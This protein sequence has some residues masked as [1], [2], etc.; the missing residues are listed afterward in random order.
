MFSETINHEFT[1]TRNVSNKAIINNN[2]YY[3]RKYIYLIYNYFDVLMLSVID[4]K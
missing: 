2:T 1:D 4:R 3:H